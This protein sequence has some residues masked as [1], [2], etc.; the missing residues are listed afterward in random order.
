M[1]RR[2]DSIA[3][4]N[5]THFFHAEQEGIS[6]A[7]FAVIVRGGNKQFALQAEDVLG[8]SLVP[9]ASLKPPQENFDRYQQPYVIGVTLE[10]L[11][12]L[13]LDKLVVAKGFVA[14]KSTV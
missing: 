2:G 9:S 5:L 12:L 11:V 4:V 1:R 7:D 10:G 14:E 8:V 6:D 3:L 13:D